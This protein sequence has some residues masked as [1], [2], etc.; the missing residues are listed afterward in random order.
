MDFLK[1]KGFG[2][3]FAASAAHK[4]FSP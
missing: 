1:G 4:Q 3:F 2:I